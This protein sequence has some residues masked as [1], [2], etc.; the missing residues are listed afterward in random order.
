M[1]DP[2]KFLEEETKEAEKETFAF[3]S[4]VVDGVSPKEA[5]STDS[6][7]LDLAIGGGLQKGGWYELIGP[8]SGGKT[9]TLYHIIGSTIRS[10]PYDIKG[11]FFDY[12]GRIP[13]LWFN[14]ITGSSVED[15]FGKKDIKGNWIVEP[16]IKYYK[17]SSGDA[18][19][20][21]MQK[22][23][24]KMPDKKKIYDEKG[25]ASWFYCWQPMSKKGGKKSKVGYS[26]K[27]L[28]KMLEGVYYKKLLK[29][30]G[31]FFVPIK[32][33]FSGPEYI[34]F[35]DSWSSMVPASISEDDSD[36]R[37]QSAR[38][39]GKYCN[40][41]KE[42]ISS[43]GVILVGIN[44]IRQ[45][46]GKMFGNPEYGTGGNTLKHCTDVR[47]R[48]QSISNKFGTGLIEEVGDKSY[49][50]YL[51]KVIKNKL[52]PCHESFYGRWWIKNKNESGYGCDP[53]L[54]TYNYLKM[55]DQVIKIG[56]KKYTIK[57]KGAN[58][59]NRKMIE[60]L[61][62]DYTWKAFEKNILEEGRNNNIR[63]ACFKQISS[64]KGIK[65]YIS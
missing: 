26:K 32:N 35:I 13:P 11:M 58:K 28:Q 15:V 57:L 52:A 14:N 43:K 18:G 34:I 42:L 48:Y 59:K 31:L 30:T 37:A 23:L 4:G 1:F 10:I 7:S 12:E 19:L 6:L 49:N 61:N 41:L 44:Q 25:K 16:Q 46:P 33:N 22:V 2:R 24:F 54:D 64:G 38:M 5:I 29:E 56:N 17:L 62:K 65:L 50:H 51:C 60:S 45:D 9:T 47:I 3:A 55:T 21:L 39:F 63:K 20:S 8:E 27:D 53:V 40:Y 36:A